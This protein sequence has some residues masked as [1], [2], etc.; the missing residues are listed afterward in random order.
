[1]NTGQWIHD[2]GIPVTIATVVVI[3]VLAVGTA[4]VAATGNQAS[5]AQDFGFDDDGD[6]P[7]F[8]FESDDEPGFDFGDGD[9]PGSG[10]DDGDENE[11]GQNELRL[12]LFLNLQDAS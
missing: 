8:G 7:G 1:M 3:G 10:D 9:G 5:I 4:P 6:G 2:A 11:P 12:D